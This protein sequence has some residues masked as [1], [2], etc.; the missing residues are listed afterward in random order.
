[1]GA[2]REVSSN[3][4]FVIIIELSNSTGYLTLAAEYQDLAELAVLSNLFT[5]GGSDKVCTADALIHWLTAKKG[6]HQ[7]RFF[8][9]NMRTPKSRTK[10]G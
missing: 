5:I 7:F 9:S 6:V 4:L 2:C 8:L 1:M 3:A 10:Q